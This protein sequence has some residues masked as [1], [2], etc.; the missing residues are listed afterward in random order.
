M[1][2]EHPPLKRIRE[3]RVLQ[4]DEVEALRSDEFLL[5]VRNNCGTPIRPTFVNVEAVEQVFAELDTAL[6]YSDYEG[7]EALW[8]RAYCQGV[9]FK[10]RPEL[11]AIAARYVQ[12]MWP[13]ILDELEAAIDRQDRPAAQQEHQRLHELRA[14]C[15]QLGDRRAALV[16]ADRSGRSTELEARYKQLVDRSGPLMCSLLPNLWCHCYNT[17]YFGS[18]VVSLPRAKPSGTGNS[19]YVAQSTR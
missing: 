1:Q 7:A 15:S 10:D 11:C 14:V 8:R 17:S 16:P 18:E 3:N 4:P 6:K 19:M 9:G 5:G 2:Q 13:Q 12:T